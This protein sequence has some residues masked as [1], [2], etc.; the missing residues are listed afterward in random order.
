MRVDRL[1]LEDFRNYEKVDVSFEQGLN[2]IVGRNAQGKTNL[3]EAIYC[4]TGF[5]SPRALDA[6]LVRTDQERAIVHGEVTRDNRPTRI[7]LELRPGRGRR[8][9]VNRAALPRGR[10]LGEVLAAVFFG[11]DELALI[12]GSPGERRRFLDELVVKLKP[13]REGLRKEWD[14]VLRQRNALLRAMPGRTSGPDDSLEVWDE[15]FVAAGAALTVARL[16]ALRLLAPYTAERYGSIAGAGSL[17]LSYV[18][19]WLAEDP[20]PASVELTAGDV[21]GRLASAL[22]TM[23]PREIERGQ[24]LVGPQRDDVSVVLTTSDAREIEA[25]THASQGDQRTAALALKLAEHDVL[26]AEL[27]EQPILLLDD[28]FSELDPTRRAWLAKAVSEMDQALVTTTAA[29]DLDLS[30]VRAVFEVVAG[31]VSRRE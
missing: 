18:S 7:D 23:R 26:T 13:A 25:R 2:L 6:V 3:L 22:E 20:L 19:S 15:A 31:E 4:L 17:E 21:S 14:R 12:K 10:S 16:D 11:P 30:D 24:S 1:G 5:A 27:G 9:L 8:A 29:E 28:V